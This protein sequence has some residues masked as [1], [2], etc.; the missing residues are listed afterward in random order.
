MSCPKCERKMKKERLLSD[1]PFFLCNECKII[2]IN[3]R[4]KRKLCIAEK[5][6]GKKLAKIKVKENE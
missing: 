1:I 4:G 6:I 3:K 2:T 5:K